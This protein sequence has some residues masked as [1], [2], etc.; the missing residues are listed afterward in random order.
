MEDNMEFKRGDRVDVRD[1]DAQKWLPATLFDEDTMSEDNPGGKY[2][3]K[4]DCS[5][6]VSRWLQCRHHIPILKD[7]Q[8]VVVWDNSG[9]CEN[10]HFH[11]FNGDGKLLT[12]VDGSRWAANGCPPS[13]WDNWRLPTAGELA[14]AGIDADGWQT[15]TREDFK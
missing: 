1:G 5:P 11:S 14:E 10:R 12:H 3:A 6:F 4:P 13:A 7:G 2:L 8:P 9:Y 15:Q